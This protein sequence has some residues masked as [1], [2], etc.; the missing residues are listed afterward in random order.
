VPD[1]HVVGGE[2][3]FTLFRFPDGDRP[4]ANDAAE[5]IGVPAVEGGSEDGEVGWA[6][7][8]IDAQVGDK[9]LAVVQAAIPSENKPRRET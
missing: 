1:G 5:T 6:G 3:E 7:I 4:I 8:K 2:Q 9:H